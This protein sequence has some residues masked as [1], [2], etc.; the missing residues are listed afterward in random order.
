MKMEF[1]EVR[2]LRAYTGLGTFSCVAG[3]ELCTNIPEIDTGLAV[4]I[5]W[6]SSFSRN[7]P[8]IRPSTSMEIITSLGKVRSIGAWLCL[9]CI[10]SVLICCGKQRRTTFSG[11]STLIPARSPSQR[12]LTW[13]IEHGGIFDVSKARLMLVTLRR[14]LWDT[15]YTSFGWRKT[16]LQGGWFEQ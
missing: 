15:W 14:C 11:I 8:Y 10:S 2:S 9:W 4:V 1:P 13:V 12:N 6:C 5:R 3:P 16:D 7:E